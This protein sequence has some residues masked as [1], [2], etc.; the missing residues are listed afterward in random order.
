MTNLLVRPAPA[1]RSTDPLPTRPSRPAQSAA[2]R[3][4]AAAGWTALIGM[5]VLMA[6]SVAGWFAANS[7]TF[8][9]ALRVGGLGWLVSNG[10]GLHVG[11][12]SI[13]LVPLGGVAVNGW[14][15]HR[16]G[17]WVG[18]HI[19]GVGGKELAV[20]ACALAGTYSAITVVAALATR[21]S[22]AEVGVGR[23]LVAAFLIAIAFGGTGVLRGAGRLHD[24][25]AALPEE[26]R[27]TAT[28][29]AAGL[30]ALLGASALLLVG[31][32]GMHFWT[33]VTL[34]EQMHAGLVGG[35]IATLI[36][37]AF[38]PNAV[39]CAGAFASGPGF[40]VGT[41]TV[42]AP[43]TAPTGNLPGFPLLAAVPLAPTALWL[44]FGLLLLPVLAGGVAG[45]LAVRKFPLPNLQGT[46]VRGGLAG[47]AAGGAFGILTVLSVGS[48]GPGRMDAFGP[49][50]SVVLA[51]GLICLVAGAAAAAASRAVKMRRPKSR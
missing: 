36:G 17:R 21:S 31:S 33:A 14:L 19:S 27:A 50:P 11:S 5:S 45:E 28:G 35:A 29:G 46:V 41:A 24:V 26:A 37:L 39:L 49:R 8:G 47:L 48:V 34:A 30:L 7:G 32:L 43:G 15:L 25:F 1:P 6:A 9:D 38:V 42:V 16:A 18:I 13:T 22:A 51:T 40:S 23:P 12:A 3:G 20:G 10:S 4:S 44:E 2:L